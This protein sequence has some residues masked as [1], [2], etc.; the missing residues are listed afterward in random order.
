MGSPA[1]EG[2]EFALGKSEEERKENRELGSVKPADVSLQ[3]GAETEPDPDT[4]GP[5]TKS[6]APSSDD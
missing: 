4:R 6:D 5:D 3:P 2:N 1:S